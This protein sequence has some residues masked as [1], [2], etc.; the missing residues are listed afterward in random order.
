ML[1]RN[2]LHSP[3]TRRALAAG[4]LVLSFGGLVLVQAPVNGTGIVFAAGANST[5]FEGPGLSGS[6]SLSHGALL[7]GRQRTF[8]ELRVR[9]DEQGAVAH[10]RAP[11]AM[12]IML[13]TSGSMDG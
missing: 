5:A 4:A 10:E 3:R 2:L 11:L 13:D 8:V 6:F 1:I 12:V 9:A 7:A